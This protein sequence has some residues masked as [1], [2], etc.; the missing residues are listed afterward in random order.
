MKTQYLLIFMVL[1]CSLILVACSSGSKDVPSLAAT[2]T[3]GAAD[4]ARDDEALM[5]EFTECLREEGFEVMDPVVDSD[6]NI[7][8][9][10]INWE[11][12]DESRIE[13]LKET[14]E[15]CMATIEGITLEKEK[16]DR[17]A[18]LDEYLKISVC[19]SEAGFD[20]GEPTE[21]TLDTWMTNLKNTFNWD[22]PDA[23][24]VIDNCFGGGSGNGSKGK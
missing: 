21:E 10:E 15:V 12:M 24:E 7:Q 1:V 22:D 4:E 16:V 17:S 18:Q 11:E 8:L 14:Y 9:P 2:P 20:V 19:M 5:L 23:Q 3:P 13:E 6:G